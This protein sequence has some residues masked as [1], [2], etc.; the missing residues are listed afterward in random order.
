M[1]QM[2]PKT[3]KVL[4]GIKNVI[5]V[6]LGNFFFALSVVIFIMPANVMATGI[7]GVALMVNH[8]TGFSVSIFVAVFDVA[9][10]FL[11][12][13]FLGKRFFMTTVLSTIVYPIFLELLMRIIPE[14]FCLTDNV[15]LN[16]IFAGLSVGISLGFVFRAGS[17]TGGMDVP[18]LVVSKY[19]HIP[20][21]ISMY[22][23][24][25]VIILMQAFLHTTE[26][27]LYS[28]ILLIITSIAIDK[29]SMLGV[30]KTEVKVISSK[31]KEITEAIMAELDRGVTLLSSEGGYSGEQTQLVL[32]VVSRRELPRLGK[33]VK[34]IDPDC[35]VVIT[36]VREVYGR[37]FTSDKSYKSYE[38]HEKAVANKSTVSVKTDDTGNGT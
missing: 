36:S 34:S 22:I 11:G 37:G 28:V 33:I 26:E 7:T 31:H 35:F 23:F 15:L 18:V 6:L 32:S 8:L 2:K 20:V 27:F 5:I 25:I 16:V 12:L 3:K 29:T 1:K 30:S 21:S 13:A 19:C 14:G 24:D 17:S 38:I 4:N 9:I 10:L